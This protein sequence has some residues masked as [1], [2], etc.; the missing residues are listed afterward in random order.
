MS[1]YEYKVVPAPKKGLKV[2]GVKSSEDRFAHALETVMNTLGAEGWEYQRSDTLPSEERSGL[3]G[4][5]TTFQNMLVFRRATAVAGDVTEPV[6]VDTAE[7]RT[8]QTIAA[9]A[10]E[11][12][13][14][15][16][17][18]LDADPARPEP[19]VAAE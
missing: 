4:R 8:T 17:K 13:L 11:T 7:D 6:V 5:V 16:A 12:P 18:P 10:E 19:K 2:K 3:T 1:Q 14:V 9:V 15:E